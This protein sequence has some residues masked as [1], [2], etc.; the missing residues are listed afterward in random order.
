M[1]RL[2]PPLFALL[3]VVLSSQRLIVFSQI[4]ILEKKTLSL[5]ERSSGTKGTFL[6][7]PINCLLM[8]EK[9][10]SLTGVGQL[11]LPEQNC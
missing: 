3:S 5:M 11:I 10:M 9:H 7:R 8:K 4:H 2:S 1:G 6:F